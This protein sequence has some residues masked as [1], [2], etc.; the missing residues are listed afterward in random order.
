MKSEVTIGYLDD[1]SMGDKSDTVAE[2]FVQLEIKAHE[3]GLTLNR[4]KCEVIGRKHKN[5]TNHNSHKDTSCSSW[6]QN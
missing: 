2:D 4:E 1:F 5:D 6:N 3:L